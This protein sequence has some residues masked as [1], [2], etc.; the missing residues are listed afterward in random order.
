MKAWIAL[1]IGSKNKKSPDMSN[2]RSSAERK[3]TDH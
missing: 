1:G 2:T 3:G